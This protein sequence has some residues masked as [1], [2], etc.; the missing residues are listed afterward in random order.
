M[1]TEERSTLSQ[2]IAEVEPYAEAKPDIAATLREVVG[3]LLAFPAAN[4]SEAAAK[5]RSAAYE[6]ALDDVPTW[7]VR[8]AVK[9]WLRGDVA[10]L[11]ERA[12][13]A[14]PPSPPQ[15]R[16]LVMDEWAKARGALWRYRRLANGKP[17]VAKPVGSREIPEAVKAIL[18]GL[19]RTAEA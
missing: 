18:K 13:L 3:L 7:A 5:A 6:I 11:G 14:F 17:E 12:N 16:G 15:L 10:C 8:A 1:T 4:V 2:L 19:A 9:R